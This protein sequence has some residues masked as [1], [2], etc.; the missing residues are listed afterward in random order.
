MPTE[1]SRQLLSFSTNGL[2]IQIVN[3]VV[4][5]ADSIHQAVSGSVNF[6]EI[7]LWAFNRHTSA[8]DLSIAFGGISAKDLVQVSIP[9]DDGLFAIINGQNLNGGLTVKAFASVAN[10]ITIFGFVTRLTVT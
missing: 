9:K 4:G 5:S 2:G 10:V 1:N 8:V 7:H 3:T 6:D